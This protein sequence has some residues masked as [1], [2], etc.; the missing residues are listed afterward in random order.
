M[1][2]SKLLILSAAL[3]TFSGLGIAQT[4]QNS[5]PA[6]PAVAPPPA[7]LHLNGIAPPQKIQFPPADPKN[8]TAQ[9]PTAQEVNA[10]L[11]QLW[12]YDPNRTWQVD[13]IQTTKAPNVSRVTI[14]VA[15]QG[16]S[17]TPATTV[18]FVTPDGQHAIAGSDVIAFGAHPFA[19]TQEK[20]Q[21]EATGPYKGS[22][23]KD[24]M[25]VEFADL[26]CPH[27][28]EAAATMDHLATDFP[29][30]RIVFQNFPLT[31]VHPAAEKAAEYGVCVAQQKGNAAFFQYV[32]A[33]YD[34]QSALVTNADETLNNAATKAG[35]NASAIGTCAAAAPAKAAVASSVKLGQEVGVDQTPLLFVNGRPIPVAGVPYTTLKQIVAYEAPQGG[36][37]GGSPAAGK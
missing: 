22:N 21:Q 15:E 14:L 7:P 26:E 3:V 8:F 23:S 9:S 33:V 16:V 28:K 1:I 20:L 10:F 11:K 17:H 25:L 34:A 37:A 2:K 29:N 27:C 5:Q 32:Q 30:A 4:S 6:S 24:L 13:G 36:S 19:A 12:G 31:N 18:F 35:A